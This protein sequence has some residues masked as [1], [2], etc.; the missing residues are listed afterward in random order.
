MKLRRIGRSIGLVAC[1]IVLGRRPK[2]AVLWTIHSLGFSCTGKA[3]LHVHMTNGDIRLYKQMVS[4][5]QST[6]RLR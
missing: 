6:V 4:V 5:V 3:L 2:R 1:F